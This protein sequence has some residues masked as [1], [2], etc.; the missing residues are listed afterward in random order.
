MSSLMRLVHLAQML[1][2]TYGAYHSY[3]AITNLQTY[4]ATSKKLAEWSDEAARQLHKTRTTQGTAAITILPL[5]RLLSK[6]RILRQRLPAR[7][8]LRR[9]AVSRHRCDARAQPCEELLGAERRQD[10]GYACAVTEYGA[11]KR[12]RARDGGSA[13]GA[14]VGGVEL[15]WG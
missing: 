3:V 9:P 6:P 12:G 5:L 7:S 13:Q 11:V 14:A 10:G 4:E 2:S 1:L 8:R 15:G